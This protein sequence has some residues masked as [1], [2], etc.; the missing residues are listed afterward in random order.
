[1]R[2]IQLLETQSFQKKEQGLFKIWANDEI[3]LVGGMRS[4]SSPSGYTR[5]RFIA[6]DKSKALSREQKA[7]LEEDEVGKLEIF[8]GE[9]DSI[10]GVV[11]LEMNQKRSGF[12]TKLIRSLLAS[13]EDGLRV[14][15][16]RKKAFGFWKKVGAKFYSDKNLTKEITKTNNYK[17]PSIPY[18]FISKEETIEE[19]MVKIIGAAAF[20]ISLALAPATFSYLVGDAPQDEETQEIISNSQKLLAQ[21]QAERNHTIDPRIKINEETILMLARTIWGEARN[22]GPDGMRAIA[23]VIVNRAND[24]LNKERS[25]RLYGKGIRGVIEK[26]K[27]FSAWNSNDPNREKMLTLDPEGSTLNGANLTAW[28]QALKI[29]TEV[30]EGKS[31]DI[32]H[33]ATHYHTTGIKPPYWADE[34]K[35]VAELGGH[36]FY[37]D[38]D[39]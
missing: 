7:L 21:V 1:M 19:S 10:Y 38:I 34:N 18:G 31:G 27:A 6:Y 23:N 35:K 39:S 4:G 5:V 36:I 12:G 13:T 8:I 20:G 26:N 3:C 9:D 32:T 16:I 25:Y 14:F 17:L 11:N 15:D 29:A 30:V 2:L 33:G 24:S 22:Q 28:K 37:R